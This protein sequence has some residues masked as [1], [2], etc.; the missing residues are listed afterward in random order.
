MEQMFK[1]FAKK[2]EASGRAVF[3]K[4]LEFYLD[5]LN[6]SEFEKVLAALEEEILA[7]KRDIEEMTKIEVESIK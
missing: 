7:L 4:S 2:H 1:D 6:K 5:F 3:S